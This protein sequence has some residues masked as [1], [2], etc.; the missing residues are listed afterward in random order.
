MEVTGEITYRTA[1]DI[2]VR[3]I[4]PYAVIEKGWHI[5]YFGRQHHSYLGTYGDQTAESSLLSTYKTAVQIEERFQEI[6]DAWALYSTEVKPLEATIEK[7]KSET[8]TLRKSFKSRGITQREYQ[9]RLQRVQDLAMKAQMAI[10]G[11]KWE[12]HFQPFFSLVIGYGER[13]SVVSYIQNRLGGDRHR[14]ED[15][16]K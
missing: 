6:S 5:P 4:S 11:A 7:S 12:R 16:K 10:E 14:S 3:S 9:S 13:N 1:S 2:T 8:R 15:S